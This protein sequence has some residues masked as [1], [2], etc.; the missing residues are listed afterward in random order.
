VG[1]VITARSDDGGPDAK[2]M[3]SASIPRQKKEADPQ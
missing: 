2:I 1:A 3:V